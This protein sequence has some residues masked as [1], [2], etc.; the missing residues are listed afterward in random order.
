M[1]ELSSC[2]KIKAPF[3][4]IALS[5]Y[6]FIERL[7]RTV[8]ASGVKDLFFFSREG[9]PLKEM[10]DFYQ[11]IGGRCVVRTHYLKVSRRSTFLISL[12]PLATEQFEVLFRQ[13]RNISV[14]DFLKSL[15][16]EEYATIF[17]QELM[18][19]VSAFEE[20]QQDL[21][22]SNIFR[23]LLRATKFIS[24]YENQ[25]QFRGEAFKVYLSSFDEGGKLPRKMHVVD[26]GWKGSIQDNLY[27]FLQQHFETK[28]EIDGYYVGL[29]AP[30]SMTSFNR[31][32]G[33]LFSNL[34]GISPDFHIFNEN[35][36]LFEVCL[37]ADH[38]SAR[39]YSAGYD[40]SHAVMEDNLCTSDKTFQS[41]RQV[42]NSA[43]E[44][45]REFTVWVTRTN[46]TDKQILSLVRKKHYRMVFNPSM[47]EIDWI[48]SVSHTENF[49]VFR[50][51]VFRSSNHST[52]IWD[53]VRFGWNL[54]RNRGHYD[55]GFWPWLNVKSRGGSGLGYVYSLIRRYQNV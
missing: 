14:M 41:I 30:G 35:R 6:I 28:V 15:D 3:E 55:L 17:A 39:R 27:N 25:R 45:F 7:H 16:L 20:N 31:K 4:D 52:G 11:S 2:N 42:S 48:L 29:I 40:G 47:A 8:A 26:V 34:G 23:K 36:S 32:G 19:P 51:S 49:G 38:G 5:L 53:T 37:Q 46:P 50:E 54:I 24:E 12:G 43:M 13:Y 33:L 22:S 18:L 21:P 1:V 9:Q 10:F 44:L